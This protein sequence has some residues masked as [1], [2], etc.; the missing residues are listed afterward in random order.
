MMG[1][2]KGWEGARRVRRGWKE[3]ANEKEKKNK[4]KKKN[5]FP[6]F[7]RRLTNLF[8]PMNFSFSFFSH[9]PSIL[10]YG[11]SSFVDLTAIS[12]LPLSWHRTLP[13]FHQVYS[14]FLFFIFFF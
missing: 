5:L 3:G 10:R 9:S 8:F 12:S 1:V 13:G 4:T 7:C 2:W 11:H 14:F 6:I